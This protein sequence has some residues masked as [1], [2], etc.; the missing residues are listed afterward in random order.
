[1]YDLIIKNGTCVTPSGKE[2]VDI[3]IK[4]SKIVAIGKFDGSADKVIDAQNLHVLPGIIDSQVHFREPGNEH[5]EDL[6][7]GT[8]AA[9]LGG[10]TAIFEMPNTNPPTT[11]KEALEDKIS[12]M[13]NRSWCDYAFFIGGTPVKDTNWHELEQLPGCAGIK[14]FM[15]SSTGNLLVDQDEAIEDILKNS[16]RRV[17]VH[18]EDEARLKERFH[19]AQEGGH[20]RFHHK[21]R[22]EK[23][24]LFAT[25]RLLKIAR[26]TGHVVN[27]LH[28]TTKYEMELLA[29][30]KDVATVEILPQHLTFTDEDYEKQGSFVQMNPPIRT[31]DHQDALWKALNEGIVDVMGSDHAP[32][33]KEEKAKTYPQSPSGMPGVQTIVPIML[34][35][36]N[37]GRL[38]LERFVDLMAGGPARIY[39]IAGKGRIA[40]GYDADFTIVDM[41]EKRTITNDWIVSKCGWTPY[42]GKEVQGWPTHTIIR[43]NVIMQ[44]DELVGGQTGETVKFQNTL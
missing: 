35:Y 16:C 23:T 18:C 29:D 34:N 37:Q 3:A 44:N 26:K 19:I 22:D 27:V 6:E 31:K 14:I 42:N 7:A 9:V 32:H 24:A 21:W 20:A 10:V 17:A 33:T 28:V 1:M 41:N 2:K 4:D 43:G 15:G 40:V 36:V 38:T 25:Q 30:Y 5:K 13:K 8:R 11:S 39:N 12:R